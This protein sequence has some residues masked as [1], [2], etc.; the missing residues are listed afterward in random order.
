M[1]ADA[2]LPSGGGERDW[3][4]FKT[5]TIEEAV[6]KWEI[7]SARDSDQSDNELGLKQYKEVLMEVSYVQ[8]TS[9]QTD[10]LVA[11][12][13][14]G[15]G[16]WYSAKNALSTTANTVLLLHIRRVGELYS[17][18]LLGQVGQHATQYRVGYARTASNANCACCRGAHIV[19]LRI[20]Q[21]VGTGST[22][23]IWG[24]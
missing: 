20:P 9:S 18:I 23:K 7:G 8:P 12:N 13:N 21:A 1:P 14:S 4:L 11:V 22:I 2:V 6:A 19:Y 15:G 5:I 16:T 17:E 10:L 24:R 3:E